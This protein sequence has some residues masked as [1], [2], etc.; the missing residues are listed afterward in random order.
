MVASFYGVFGLATLLDSSRFQENGNCGYVLKPS[1]SSTP[2]SLYTRSPSLWKEAPLGF[3][4]T[5]NTFTYVSF[6]YGRPTECFFFV[7]C[8]RYWRHSNFL[9]LPLKDVICLGSKTHFHRILSC[10]FVEFPAIVV[11]TK[12]LWFPGMD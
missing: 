6:C 4:L 11:F 3:T 12:R 2:N 1:L 5:V 10:Q 8:C 9:V 7:L